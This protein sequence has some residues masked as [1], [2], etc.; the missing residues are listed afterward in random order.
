[1]KYSIEIMERFII[2]FS[3]ALPRSTKEEF[4]NSINPAFESLSNICI[5]KRMI[6]PTSSLQFTHI[7]TITLYNE[8]TQMIK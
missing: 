7:R 3:V 6:S 8:S 5:N 2:L 1:M 4:I